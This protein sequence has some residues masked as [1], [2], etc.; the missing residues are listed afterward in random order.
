LLADG[1]K[2]RFDRF[3]FWK[4]FHRETLLTK[5]GRSELEQLI[6]KQWV[7]ER[8]IENNFYS[9]YRAF[10][11]KLYKALLKHNPDFSG[12]KGRLVRIAIGSSK[13]GWFQEAS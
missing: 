8:E 2:A 4:L 6:A 1:E 10:R 3:L 12:T 13:N 7:K 9:E 5:G 11:E